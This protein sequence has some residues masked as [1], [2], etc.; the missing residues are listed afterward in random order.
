[1]FDKSAIASD[2]NHLYIYEDKEMPSTDYR[3]AIVIILRF[4]LHSW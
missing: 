3:I 2:L 4:E 1:M